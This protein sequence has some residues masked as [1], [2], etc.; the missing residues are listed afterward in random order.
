MN[1]KEGAKDSLRNC[2]ENKLGV[3]EIQPIHHFR[4]GNEHE[5][6]FPE[7]QPLGSEEAKSIP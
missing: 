3:F 2:Q 7:L 4:L 5:K 1:F 6:Y